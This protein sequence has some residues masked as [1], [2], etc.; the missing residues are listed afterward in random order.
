MDTNLQPFTSGCLWSS[1]VLLL[2]LVLFLGVPRI[3]MELRAKRILSQIANYE[4]K[5]FF[6]SFDSVFPSQKR[7]VMDKKIA[8][9]ES[10]GWIYLRSGEVNPLKTIKYLG[11]GLN[12][13]FVRDSVQH[14]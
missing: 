5:S 14:Q 11:G 8:E 3:R 13:Y 7:A 2:A 4:I 6:V 9:M 12:M 1:L 10:Q